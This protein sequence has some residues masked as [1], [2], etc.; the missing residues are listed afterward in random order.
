MLYF[1][2]HM[3]DTRNMT[4]QQPQLIEILRAVSDAAKNYASITNDTVSRCRM[5]DRVALVETIIGAMEAE[6]NGE[7]SFSKTN[8]MLMVKD[9]DNAA[10]LTRKDQG[11]EF[12]AEDADDAITRN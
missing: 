10:E 11:Y 7:V 2:G 1:L 4:Q 9:M 8:L 5:L 3:V 6:A 12:S